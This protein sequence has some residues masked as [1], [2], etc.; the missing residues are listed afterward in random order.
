MNHY[1]LFLFIAIVLV[2]V[3]NKSLKMYKLAS[4]LFCGYGTW[5]IGF[6]DI[7]QKDVHIAEA[8]ALLRK[9]YHF[10]VKSFH[11]LLVFVLPLNFFIDGTVESMIQ[12]ISLFLLYIR[13]TNHALENNF[14]NGV[15]VLTKENYDLCVNMTIVRFC[16]CIVFTYLQ[17]SNTTKVII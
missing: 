12:S 8:N 1:F 14:D 4:W 6:V 5:A 15:Y 2:P 17:N 7:L 3:L 10:S 11:F 9:I 16:V 13:G